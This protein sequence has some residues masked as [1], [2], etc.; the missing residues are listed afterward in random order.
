MSRKTNYGNYKPYKKC[1]DCQYRAQ[2]QAV[3]N[4]DYILIT[5]HMRNCDP[6]RCDKYVKGKRLQ[7]KD[8]DSNPRGWNHRQPFLLI[9]VKK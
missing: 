8:D 4:C 1:L 9:G 2:D 7:W 6:K 5:G 3:N